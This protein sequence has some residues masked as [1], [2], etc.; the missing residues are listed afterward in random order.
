VA[1]ADDPHAVLGVAPGATQDEIRAA[2]RAKARAHHPDARPD[3]P[4]AAE[5]FRR[6]REAYQKLRG[7]EPMTKKRAGTS[8]ASAKAKPRPASSSRDVF[9][10]AFHQK[11]E[12]A[13]YGFHRPRADS[14]TGAR[15][16]TM[17]VP[18]SAA[19]LGGEHVLDVEYDGLLPRR[20]RVVLPP[21]VE[22]DQPFKLEGKIVRAV[23]KPHPFLR[24]DGKNVILDLPLSVAELALGARVLVPTVDGSVEIA[25]PPGSKPGQRLRLRGKGVAGK[26][27]QLC[28]LGLALPSLEKEGV[29]EA[30]LRLERSDDRSPRPWDP[31]GAK[32]KAGPD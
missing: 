19:V 3:D 14:S 7:Q 22:Q 31:E 32:T 6:I 9:D 13:R 5:T 2:F 27:D 30:L 17:T 21:G 11:R 8:K 24:R 10:R 29:R 20:V 1:A 15:A 18:F 12:E 16:G 4:H 26:G 23:V 28:V 25:V